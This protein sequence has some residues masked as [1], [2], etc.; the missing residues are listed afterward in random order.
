MSRHQQAYENEFGD[1][2]WRDTPPAHTSGVT[3]PEVQR[4]ST[5]VNMNNVS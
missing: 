3:M 4:H 5:R 1:D 2:S